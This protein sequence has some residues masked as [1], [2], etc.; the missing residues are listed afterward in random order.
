[1][2]DDP[3]QHF[4]KLWSCLKQ[5]NIAAELN[6][7]NFELTLTYEQK[8]LRLYPQFSAAPDG[9]LAYRPEPS[10]GMRSFI[11]WRPYQ[12]KSWPLASD[13]LRFKE[14]LRAKGV[15]TPASSQDPKA[16]M[17]NVLVKPNGSSFGKGIRGPYRLASETS[18]NR[19]LEEYYEEFIDGTIVKIWYWDTTAVAAEVVPPTAVYGNGHSTVRELIGTHARII[20]QKV[21]DPAKFADYFAFRGVAL[22]SVPAKDERCQIDY[23]YNS[24][25]RKSRVAEDVR[26]GTD[27]FFG[28]EGEL[29]AWGQIFWEAIPDNLRFGTVYSIDGVVD[30]D[31]RLWILEMNSNPAVHPYAYRPMIASWVDWVNSSWK[32]R[33]EQNPDARNIVSAPRH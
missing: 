29:A 7:G 23:R 16:V 6:G 14:Y 30:S 8:Q 27:P 25:F 19:D 10:S 32:P 3:L 4:R 22:D 13:K 12:L 11:G 31:Q 20:R 18:L 15:R 17:R 5:Y 2:L 21:P 28:L 24:V 9:E 1:M 33:L 26:I